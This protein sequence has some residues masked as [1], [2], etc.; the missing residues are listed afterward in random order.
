MKYRA[1]VL[2]DNKFI[3]SLLTEFLI[4]RDYEIFT[5]PTPKVCPLQLMPECRC[6]KNEA[7]V[8]IIVSDVDMP[9]IT[10]LDFIE[11]HQK[12]GCK[13]QNVALMSGGWTEGGLA[14]AKELG[15]KIF[16]KPFSLAEFE[17]WLDEVEKNINPIR[18]LR[19]WFQQN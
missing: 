15:C 8:D 4:N 6:K 11:N 18:E 2:D 16:F 14:Q 10:G 12:K 1:V 17:G 9:G 7:C 19:D 5:F 3:L 13:C